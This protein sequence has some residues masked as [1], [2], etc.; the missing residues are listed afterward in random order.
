MA[1]LG[2]VQ[3]GRLV[4][5]IPVKRAPW[6]KIIGAWRTRHAKR[7]Y[8][9]HYK[10]WIIK[11]KPSFILLPE[12][13]KPHC[14]SAKD[15][16]TWW[17]SH[18]SPLQQVLFQSL[19]WEIHC[20]N[21]TSDTRCNM[22]TL[23]LSLSS[24][25]VVFGKKKNPVACSAIYIP[26]FFLLPGNGKSHLHIIKNTTNIVKTDWFVLKYIFGTSCI[27][28][29]TNMEVPCSRARGRPRKTWSDCDKAECLQPWCHWSTKQNR[30]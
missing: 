26:S 10:C 15:P 14:I 5:Q 21:P 17:S 22:K 3:K 16:W 23:V 4:L 27:K 25:Q 11:I 30:L 12:N 8:G 24:S 9:K 2:V 19:A 18:C 28:C 6:R 20:H 29:V 13:I 7:A 1:I